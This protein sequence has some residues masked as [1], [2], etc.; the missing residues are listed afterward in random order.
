KALKGLEAQVKTIDKHLNSMGKQKKQ[1]LEDQQAV[2]MVLMEKQGAYSAVMAEIE[3]MRQEKD[4]SSDQVTTL[5]TDL[6]KL[7]D[8]KHQL[9][10]RKTELSTRRQGLSEELDKLRDSATELI[11]KTAASKSLFGS[12]EK[13]CLD[14]EA[15]VAGIER[16]IRQLDGELESTR[17]DIE[18]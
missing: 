14:Q 1:H 4:R 16:T 13:K 15:L 9:E 11:G 12:F 3:V 6:Q 5:H 17:E 2:Q 8:E 18:T 10:V 7:R